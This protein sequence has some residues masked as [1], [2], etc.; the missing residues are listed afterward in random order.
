MAPV[1][2]RVRR[3]RASAPTWRAPRNRTSPTTS[4]TGSR[5]SARSRSRTD[6]RS[7]RCGATRNRPP[8]RERSP[9]ERIAR[10]TRPAASSR[11]SPASLEEVSRGVAGVQPD[12]PPRRRR[13]GGVQPR[14]RAGHDRPPRERRRAVGGPGRLRPPA[15]DAARRRHPRRAPRLGPRRRPARA[16]PTSRRRCS[17]CCSP[18]IAEAG[19]SH[20][21]G[22]YTQR[23]RDRVRGRGDRPPHLRA[24]SWPPSSASAACCSAPSRRWRRTRQL[25]PPPPRPPRRPPRRPTARHRGPAGSSARRAA[26][27]ARR[28]RRAG[29]RE[30]RGEARHEPAPRAADPRGARAADDG[31]E[32]APHLHRQP[33]HREDHRR[34]AARPD[35]PHPRRRRARPPRGDRPRRPGGGLRRADRAPGAGALRRGRPGR[36]AHRRGVLAGARRRARLRTGGDRRHREA[37]RRSPRPDRGGDGRLPRRDGGARSA[38]TR[39]CGRG[40]RR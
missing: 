20:A 34:S 18:P 2:D 14:V 10:R 12:G 15:R 26:R 19:S 31:P 37:H 28:A 22:Y 27:R 1:L 17:R 11:W 9:D 6:P 23:R 29:R 24:A 39:A 4:A 16:S 40:S 36:A 32:P 21:R 35:L 5:W 13:P 25:V 8:P 30:A 33:R 7:G 38:R 3:R